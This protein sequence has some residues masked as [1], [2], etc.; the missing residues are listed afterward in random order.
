[1][2]ETYAARATTLF[3]CALFAVF[4]ALKGVWFLTK[5]AGDCEC[6]G[7]ANPRRIDG[8]S[9]LTAGGLFLLA[10]ADLF[11]VTHA[12]PIGWIWRALV[13]TLYG[14]GSGWIV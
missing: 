10:A 6:Y 3:V 2:L 4:F 1:M 5:R 12:A 13:A 11:A 7:G 8:A 9:L 14:G